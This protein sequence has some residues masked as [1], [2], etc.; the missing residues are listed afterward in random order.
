MDTEQVL[1][2][3]V[4]PVEIIGA[5]HVFYARMDKSGRITVSPDARA[6]AG[7]ERELRRLRTHRFLET[8]PACSLFFTLPSGSWLIN[9]CLDGL[10]HSNIIKIKSPKP[11]VHVIM[12]MLL[13]E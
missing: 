8:S 5:K 10:D 7:L 6:D 4:S 1:K 3:I 13:T 11:Q 12:P 2:V 9:V